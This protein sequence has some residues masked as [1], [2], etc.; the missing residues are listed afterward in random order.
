MMM[1]TE[2]S[3]AFWN[4]AVGKMQFAALVRHSAARLIAASLLSPYRHLCAA[5]HLVLPKPRPSLVSHQR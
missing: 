3:V 2:S 1:A 4:A 5:R